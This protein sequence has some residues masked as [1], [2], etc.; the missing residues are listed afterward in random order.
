MAY[1]FACLRE[2]KKAQEYSLKAIDGGYDAYDLYA[3]ITIGNLADMNNAIK[4]LNAGIEKHIPTAC[5][6]MARLHIDN[7]LEPDMCDPLKASKYLELAFQY[8]SEEEKGIV[9]YKIAKLYRLLHGM[10]PQSMRSE[11][12]NRQYYYFNVFN[13]Y[14]GAV[15]PVGGLNIDLFNAACIND[16]YSVVHTLL[17]SLNGDALFI[18]ALLLLDEEYTSTGTIVVEK[19]QGLLTACEGAIRFNHG[20]CYALMAL[21]IGSDFEASEY[22]PEETKRLLAKSKRNRF[23][24]P[25]VFESLFK[26]LMSHLDDEFKDGWHIEKA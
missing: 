6:I 3:S 2:Y 22:N 18:F 5:L 24:V 19:N 20:G 23:I 17:N 21:C 11:T 7:N 4:V 9:A 10:F 26:N 16:D 25:K 8:A 1:A 12:D 13:N 14:G 15:A